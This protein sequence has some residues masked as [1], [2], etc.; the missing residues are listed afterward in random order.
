ML[1]TILLFALRKAMACRYDGAPNLDYS[2]PKDFGMESE[3]FSF[4]SGKWLLRGERVLPKGEPKALV[5]FFHGLGAGHT[6]YTQ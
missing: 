2:F 3:P 6:A 5:V 4:R 1:A